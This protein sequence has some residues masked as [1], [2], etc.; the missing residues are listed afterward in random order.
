MFRFEEH[1]PSG[2][3]RLF[4]PMVYTVLSIYS[5]MEIYKNDDRILKL[6][7]K[8]AESFPVSCSVI[9]FTSALKILYME[10]SE[11][12]I[13]FNYLGISRRGNKSKVV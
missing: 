1:F 8:L 12:K 4:Y 3:Q 9:P 7:I 11:S 2:K 13:L 6:W 5:V 10:K